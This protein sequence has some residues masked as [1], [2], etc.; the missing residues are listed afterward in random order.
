MRKSGYALLAAAVLG[1]ALPGIRGAI[2]FRL[3]LSDLDAVGW[4]T[5]CIVAGM[6]A[7]L[8]SPRAR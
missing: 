3:P 2:P 7:V 6:V 5:I 4:A 8:F 1:F